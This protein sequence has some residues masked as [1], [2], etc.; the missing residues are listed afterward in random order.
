MSSHGTIMLLHIYCFFHLLN[1]T[2]P[3][4]IWWRWIQFRLFYKSKK[5]NFYLYKSKAETA[6]Y[7]KLF[8]AAQKEWSTNKSD[9][10]SWEH[11]VKIRGRKRRRGRW[12]WQW[13]EISNWNGKVYFLRVTKQTYK[14]QTLPRLV[15]DSLHWLIKAWG[16][17]TKTRISYICMHK[18][19]LR[20]AA[21]RIR[22]SSRQNRGI[23]RGAMRQS[24]ARHKEIIKIKS[25]NTKKREKN[26]CSQ[27]RKRAIYRIGSFSSI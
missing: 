15:L 27:L 13:C 5:Q 4:E 10:R 8:A 16:E 21:A 17:R 2:H 9:R 22:R 12:M 19:H 25:E 1:F 23:E 7:K 18:I 14:P 11:F 24:K 3:P 6:A 26:V 20:E